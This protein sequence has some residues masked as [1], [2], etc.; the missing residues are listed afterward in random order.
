MNFKS[1]FFFK[2]IILYVPA[3]NCRKITLRALVLDG[4]DA[5]L[6]SGLDN[7]VLKR[8]IFIRKELPQS[9]SRC[10]DFYFLFFKKQ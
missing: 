3:S 2:F 5:V 4:T 6:L 1:F 10:A 8:E 7:S 9:S